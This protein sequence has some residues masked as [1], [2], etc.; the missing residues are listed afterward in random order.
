MI[1]SS[2]TDREVIQH[3][4]PNTWIEQE[5]L[6]RLEAAVNQIVILKRELHVERKYNAKD[7]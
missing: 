6:D 3:Y 7:N 4:T 1:I 2:L 5:L